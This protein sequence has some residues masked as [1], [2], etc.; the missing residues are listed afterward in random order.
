ME[1]A[2][3]LGLVGLGSNC[4]LSSPQPRAVSLWIRVKKMHPPGLHALPGLL[5]PTPIH[6]HSGPP[7]PSPLPPGLSC[8][9]PMLATQ[10]GVICL[11]RPPQRWLMLPWGKQ[12]LLEILSGMWALILLAFP[13][14]GGGNFDSHI[15]CGSHAIWMADGNPCRL[16]CF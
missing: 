7:A 11:W 12:Q 3:S 15:P 5:Y 1:R 10:C 9:R 6:G 2:E 13:L 16:P 4:S 14:V 8:G